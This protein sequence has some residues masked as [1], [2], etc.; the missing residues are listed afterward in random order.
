MPLMQDFLVA[1]GV[2]MGDITRLAVTVGPGTFTGTRVGL[3]AMRGLALALNVPVAGIGSL[4]AMA[5]TPLSTEVSQIPRLVAI[6]ARRDSF[7]CQAFAADGEIL[8]APQALGLAA[9]AA[10]IEGD[11]PV[12]VIGS[13]KN[14]L[15]A[16]N[17]RFLPDAAPDFPQAGHV[18]ELAAALPPENWQGAPP[19]PLYLRP[20][21]ATLPDP[22]KA[23]LRAP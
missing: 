21:D 8:S 3:S 7:Y 2:A 14:A 10:L 17:A 19:A 16:H 15:A 22:A 13:G 4:H 6:D 11:A 5:Q 23:L 20:P 1:Q 9:A 12:A 18:A